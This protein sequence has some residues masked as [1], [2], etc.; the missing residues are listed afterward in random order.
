MENKE[1]KNEDQ[2]EVPP[3]GKDIKGLIVKIIIVCGFLFLVYR[4]IA[5]KYGW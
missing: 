4:A 3:K 2:A 1:N 5:H